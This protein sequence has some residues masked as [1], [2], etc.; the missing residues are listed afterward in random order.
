[1]PDLKKNMARNSNE[2]ASISLMDIFFF[3]KVTE[4]EKSNNY[5][6]MNEETKLYCPGDDYSKFIAQSGS[7]NTP[8]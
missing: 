2:D 5:E 8:L 3:E 7:K 1:M 4:N 6:R